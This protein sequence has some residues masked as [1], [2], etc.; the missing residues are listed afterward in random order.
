MGVSPAMIFKYGRHN[1][2]RSVVQA[3]PPVAP[4]GF[5]GAQSRGTHPLPCCPIMGSSS[6]CF[7]P[8]GR[9]S[10]GR[11]LCGDVIACGAVR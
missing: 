3:G 10:F 4:A 11:R 6:L 7:F 9:L 5:R 2:L 8:S 1:H